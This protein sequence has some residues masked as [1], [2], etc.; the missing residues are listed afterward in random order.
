[1]FTVS[2]NATAFPKDSRVV[3]TN[4]TFI[5]TGLGTGL[6][7]SEIETLSAAGSSHQKLVDLLVSAAPSPLWTAVYRTHYVADLE[8]PSLS[9]D[10]VSDTPIIDDRAI[11]TQ[12]LLDNREV[13]LL[14]RIHTGYRLG[15]M[16]ADL[17][18][19]LA[20][21]AVRWIREHIDLGNGFRVFDVTGQGYNV[22]H[23]PSGTT[24]A[25]VAVNIHKVEYY[26]QE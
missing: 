22:E 19:E 24:G 9:V 12:E 3:A 7:Y 18:V 10:V 14:V 1:V 8:L 25:E 4:G 6:T 21:A 26:E 23:A 15:P 2:G 5:L 16:D 11:N 17:S 13:Q 20:D